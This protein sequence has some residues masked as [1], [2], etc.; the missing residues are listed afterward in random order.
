VELREGKTLRVLVE[1]W[2]QEEEVDIRV[3]GQPFHFIRFAEQMLKPE[4]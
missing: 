3:K 4:E 2:N 1:W